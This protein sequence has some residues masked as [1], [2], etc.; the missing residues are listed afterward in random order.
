MST[1]YVP[2]WEKLKDPRWQKRRL[3]IMERDGFTCRDCTDD[4]ST[5]NVHHCYYERGL[6]P[7][8]YP[9]EALLTLC[10][11]CH[12]TRH[13][14]RSQLDKSLAGLSANHVDLI[15]GFAK[16]F[17]A[18]NYK[19]THLL[20]SIYQT[21]GAGYCLQYRSV[22]LMEACVKAGSIVTT[23]VVGEAAASFTRNLNASKRRDEVAAH[24]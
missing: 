3:E 15:V 21:A 18:L 14:V 4:K 13:D 19:S 11:L 7:W 8:D 24:T 16:Y 20:T 9:D 17:H 1:T 12:R 5:L 23:K 2:Y 10:E 22:E 6:D